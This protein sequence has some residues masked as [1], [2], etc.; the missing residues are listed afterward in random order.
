MY[1]IVRLAMWHY[2]F[3]EFWLANTWFFAD[4]CHQHALNCLENVH[5]LNIRRG[6]K[7]IF[8]LSHRQSRM[9][10]FEIH[11]RCKC[12]LVFILPVHNLRM[13]FLDP[14]SC[15]YTKTIVYELLSNDNW[16]KKDSTESM[17]KF[18]GRVNITRFITMSSLFNNHGVPFK[19]FTDKLSAIIKSLQWIGKRS[20]EIRDEL[21]TTLAF[22]SGK[23]LSL[24]KNLNGPYT[25]VPDTKTLPYTTVPDAKTLTLNI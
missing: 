7:L 25:T 6:K 24:S 1:R 15:L 20:S 17:K 2:L 12:Y 19:T 4:W 9:V 8:K 14:A 11:K 18:V 3:L 22:K 23:N 21:K 13:S 16:L 5:Q 10:G